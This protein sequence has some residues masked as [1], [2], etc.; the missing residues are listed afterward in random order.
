[1][2]AMALAV[3]AAII[4]ACTKEKETKMDQSSNE[5]TTVSKEG[6]M[7]AYL[8]HFKEKM[9]SAEKGAESLSLEDA[10]W[11]LEAVLNYTY[12]DAGYPTSDIQCDTFCCKLNT[13]GED[14]CLASLNEVYTVLSK[15]VERVYASCAFPDKSILSVQTLFED[16]R[17]DA[18]VIVRAIVTTRGRLTTKIRFDSTDYWSDY[19]NEDWHYGHGKCGPYAGQCNESGAP[20]ELTKLANL[21]IP[22]YGCV[23]GYRLYVTDLTSID[24][25]VV[26]D[27]YGVL[28]DVN[29]PCGYKLYYN[30]YNPSDPC[31]N[32]D[33][34]IPP[35]DMNYYLDKFPEI[36]D[37]F[38]PDGKDLI[39]ANYRYDEIIAESGDA[40]LFW[41]CIMFAVIHCEPTGQGQGA[42]L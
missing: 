23:D 3:V 4:I 5:M 21:R 19:Y 16:D 37:C 22:Q 10:C 34:C 30:P 25:N 28:W 29:S 13:E 17:N 8:K 33:H 7:S 42:D 31:H 38:R 27:Y 14:V 1:M 39:C 32:P 12:G 20:R 11:H 9:Q 41:L 36:V 35:D 24:V 18:G 6:D 40:A 26:E 2:G 15:N